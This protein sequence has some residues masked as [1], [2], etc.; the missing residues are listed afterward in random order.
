M[1]SL[2]KKGLTIAEF[3][4]KCKKSYDED[5]KLERYFSRI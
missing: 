2:R 1:E 4:E 3:W 5:K